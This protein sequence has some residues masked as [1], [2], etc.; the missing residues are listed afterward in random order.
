MDGDCYD[1]GGDVVLERRKRIRRVE[2]RGKC[3][4]VDASRLGLPV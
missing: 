3:R 2:C 4:G 1:G